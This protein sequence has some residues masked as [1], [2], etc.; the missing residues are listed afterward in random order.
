MVVFLHGR[1]SVLCWP[2]VWGRGCGVVCAGDKCKLV[3]VLAH[4]EM[5]TYG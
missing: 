4:H 3:P 5:N 2:C 1:A